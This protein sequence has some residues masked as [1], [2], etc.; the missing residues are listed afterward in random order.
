MFETGS[1][2]EKDVSRAAA[3]FSNACDAN[4]PVGCSDLGHSYL[5]GNGVEKDLERSKLFF[6]KGCSLGDKS[7]CEQVQQL[8]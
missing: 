5:V 8:P 3:L 4:D 7:G 2:V 1:G 6:R